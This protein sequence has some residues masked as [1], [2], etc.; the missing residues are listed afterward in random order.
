MNDSTPDHAMGL[1]R[2]SPQQ[3]AWQEM[4]LGM[5]IH[6]NMFAWYLDDWVTRHDMPPAA[7]QPRRLDTDQWLEAAVAMGARY[8]V[9][10]AQHGEGFCLWPTD[11]FDY[12]VRQSPWMNGKGD[13]VGQFIASCHKYRV[14][15]GIYLNF[16]HNGYCN[17]MYH[18]WRDGKGGFKP[19][20]SVHNSPHYTAICERMLTELCS[21]YGEL[22][23]LWFDGSALP[24]NLGGPDV[25]AITQRYQPNAVI[26]GATAD[27]PIA[28]CIRWIG[29]EEGWAPESCWGTIADRNTV[30]RR[31]LAS[32][33]PNGS[34]YMPAECDVPI[35]DQGRWVWRPN[36]E[37]HVF[38]LDHLLGLYTR[39][40]GRNANWLL[41]ANPDRDGLIPEPDLTRYSELGREIRRRYGR[42]LAKV[43]GPGETLTLDLPEPARIDHV[44]LAEDIREGERVRHFTV[45]A[46]VQGGW[47]RIGEG[48]C[49]GHKRL[50]AVTPTTTPR[51]RLVCTE[52]V[53]TPIL[54]EFS[55]HCSASSPAND[56]RIE[57]GTVLGEFR[58]CRNQLRYHQD[59][60]VTADQALAKLLE[61]QTRWLPKLE[62]LR[63]DSAAALG[64]D[65]SSQTAWD[66]AHALNQIEQTFGSLDSLPAQLGQLVRQMRVMESLPTPLTEFEAGPLH[67]SPTAF[68]AVEPPPASEPFRPVATVTDEQF[69]DLRSF[70]QNR[71]GILYVR[72]HWR[73][74]RPGSGR[75]VF[76]ADGPL[77][78]WVNGTEMACEPSLTNPARRDAC[79]RLIDWQAKENEIVFALGTNAG[80]AWGVFAAV[81]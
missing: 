61:L 29:H 22:V 12:S 54:R 33:D 32:G 70:H 64:S 46:Q 62:Q 34:F 73:P 39:S 78:V 16:A 2:P 7:F 21:R 76:G 11:A 57:L 14:R 52:S 55:A 17:S 36:Q 23:E 81:L 26:Y 13:V 79:Y 43:A 18:T 42:P 27:Q 31:L 51:L 41:N 69:A 65:H 30:E 3:Y 50:L 68:A 60:V 8:A 45:E 40:V 24:V 5:F 28:N 75:L 71:D 4:E 20:R 56:R 59:G 9:L 37:S 10:T 35:R 38:S 15:P 74:E 6:F 63:R 58:A 49:I 19:G 80:Q 1:P 66:I 44:I 25:T 72:T 53:G 47:E 48:A 77:K 67:P